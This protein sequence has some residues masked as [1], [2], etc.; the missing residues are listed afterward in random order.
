MLKPGRGLAVGD[1][2]LGQFQTRIFGE[3][4]LE[5]L[6]PLIERA[7]AR[8]RRD[9]RDVAFGLAGLG[10]DAVRER[11]GGGAA[12][13]DVVGRQEGCEGLGVGGR[14]D[15]D[16]LDRL[17]GFVDRLAEGREL[18]RRDH[19]GGRLLRHGVLEDR[20]LPVD[21]GLGL[22]TE[23]RDLDAE[24]LAGLAC[25]RQHDLPIVRG[26]VLDDDRDRD[27][28]GPDRAASSR[29]RQ[30]DRAD[31]ALLHDVFPLTFTSDLEVASAVL[32]GD[33][34]EEIKRAGP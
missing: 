6:R 5:A 18:R 1:L 4:F 14:V 13:L 2:V 29:H 33:G 25:A 7:D 31:D 16:D 11:I 3:L 8:Q 15:A 20:D 9:E 34:G 19:D 26:R 27:V 10:L 22:R 12:A 23:F 17:R 30:H 32:F 24:V 21:V 28:G